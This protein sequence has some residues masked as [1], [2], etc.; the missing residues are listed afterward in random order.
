MPRRCYLPWFESGLP[1]GRI[2]QS[3]LPTRRTEGVRDALGHRAASIAKPVNRNLMTGCGK[4]KNL[5]LRVEKSCGYVDVRQMSAADITM[6]QLLAD[7]PWARRA[8]FQRFHI[9]GCASCGFSEDETLAEVCGRNG[10]VTPDEVLD[11]VKEAHHA[12]EALMLDPVAARDSHDDYSWID[13][14]TREEFDAVHVPGSRHFSQELMNEI[15]TSWAKDT[16]ILIVDHHGDRSLD[17][18]AYFTGH[19]FSEVRC[20]RGGIDAYSRDA[21]PGIPRYAIESNE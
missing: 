2:F 19:G 18:A 21:D 13:I 15:M 16:R 17:A 12:D 10:E 9:G 20:L 6:G 3:L 4:V 14:R 5:N 11:A 1:A 7:F 8:L